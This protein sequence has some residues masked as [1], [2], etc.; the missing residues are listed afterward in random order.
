MADHVKPEQHLHWEP[1]LYPWPFAAALVL[2]VW[3]LGT[4]VSRDELAWTFRAG[5][6]W[7]SLADGRPLPGT[8]GGPAGSVTV[9]VAAL[10]LALRR[11]VEGANPLSRWQDLR[12]LGAFDPQNPAQLQLLASFWPTSVLAVALL[13][14]LLV[15]LIAFLVSRLWGARAGLFAGLMLAIAPGYLA[16]SRILAPDAL[17][18]GL[19]VAAL[20]ALLWALERP[21]AWGIHLC[22]GVLAGLALV[23][24]SPAA[25]LV[26]YALLLLCTT[27]LCRRRPALI[28][29]RNAALWC[30]GLLLAAVAACPRAWSAP[31]DALRALGPDLLMA[32]LAAVRGVHLP[33][34]SA[35]GPDLTPLALVGL[36]LA[37]VRL[38]L[39]ENSRR[40]PLLALLVFAAVFAAAGMAGDSGLL[41]TAL[42]T[43]ALTVAAAAGLDGLATIAVR[44]VNRWRHSRALT[45]ALSL[46]LTMATLAAIGREALAVID[47]RPYYG[48]YHN[49]WIQVPPDTAPGRG[50]GMDQLVA[51][52]NARPG[53]EMLTVATANV[54]LLAPLFVGSTVVLDADTVATAD[55]VA[56]YHGDELGPLATRLPSEPE[57]VVTVE[58]VEYARLYANRVHEPV[59]KL[60]SEGLQADDVVVLDAASPFARHYDGPAPWHEIRVESLEQAAR[61]LDELA[62][63]HWRLWHVAF[64]GADPQEIVRTLLESH[65]V[66]LHRWRVEGATVS[67]YQLP[68][69]VHF[70]ATAPDHDLSLEFPGG[71]HL[72]AAG[73]AEDE[74]QYRQ[75]IVLALQ[76]R[77]GDAPIR[78]MGFSLRLV[79]GRGQVWVQLDRLLTAVDGRP[80]SA[81]PGNSDV[82][83]EHWL[84][85][86]PGIPPGTYHLRAVL[87]THD[88]HQPLVPTGPTG[89]QSSEVMELLPVQVLPA[90]VPPTEAELSIPNRL[91]VTLAHGVELMGYEIGSE[92]VMPGLYLPLRL[93]WRCTEP[94]TVTYKAHLM[95]LDAR[96]DL[97]ADSTVELAGSEHPTS[98]WVQGEVIEGRYWVPVDVQAAP[99]EAILGLQLVSPLGAGGEPVRLGTVQV[100]A[101]EHVFEVPAMQERRKETLGQVVRLLGYDVSETRLKP[102]QTLRLTLYWQCLAPMETSYTVFTHLLRTASQMCCGHDSI[103]A[104]GT[105]PTPGWVLHEVLTDV[106][107]ITVPPDA[108]PGEYP[109]E[110]GMYDA[111]TGVRLPAFDGAGI[112]LEQDRILLRT[113]EVIAQ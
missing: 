25:V 92:S 13:N 33:E 48:L 95:L 9:A 113:V 36:A 63:G 66:L 19:A 65:A 1:L 38:A 88:T 45:L 30:I 101:V 6:L 29:L 35:L 58:G 82:R 67:A 23:N 47:L 60:F 51:Y 97:R 81:W 3:Q 41:A 39:D 104:G 89:P 20:L 68:L 94:M 28:G 5:K 93:W 22:S 37:A 16:L 32:L 75:P 80:A 44:L 15:I 49:P 52:L 56:V 59:L 12:G 99:G 46:G 27:H 10:G 96:G 100:V 17:T 71:L 86:P 73:L 70:H 18:A 61:E 108:P 76:W 111:T 26:P 31:L 11:V 40:L 106:H 103:P 57:Y 110:V 54:D 98:H 77:T 72:R 91:Q 24:Q 4:F 83:S 90:Q 105:R 21:S 69:E 109:I 102:G 7:Q 53:A 78:D 64:D 43:V 34:L 62:A 74:V 55:Y 8:Q 112:R 2:R 87:Y 84:N 50:E 107:E 42:P 85:L 14:T 79:D